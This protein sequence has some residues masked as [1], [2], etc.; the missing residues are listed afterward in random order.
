M[1]NTNVYNLYAQEC[2]PNSS[3]KA[4]EHGE[5]D[6]CEKEYVRAYLNLP[7]VQNALH[8]NT[9]KLPYS[10]GLCSSVLGS[11][12]DRPSTV[13]PIYK[14]LIAVQVKILVYSGDIDAVIPVTSTRYSVDALNL[15][16][17]TDWRP[18]FDDSLQVAGY[19]ID[20]EGLTFM[21]V[22]GAGHEMPRFQPRKAF[23]LVRLF[24]D[25]I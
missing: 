15:T 23:S 16:T 20:Y 13:L 1:G 8:A 6:P 22:Q 12:R 25:G 18:W 3:I 5:I 11:W 14:R 2:F 10:W 21:T 19:R 17:K 24:L 4:K 9:T 7:E